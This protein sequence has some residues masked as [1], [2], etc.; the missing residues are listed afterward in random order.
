MSNEHGLGRQIAVDNR[1]QLHPMQSLLPKRITVTSKSWWDLGAWLDQGQTGTCV[2]H[3]WAHWVEDSPVNPA[4]TIDPFAV[5][6]EA[7]QLDEWV[8][9]DDADV[10][11]GTSVRGGVKALQA[12]GLVEQ[13]LWAWDVAT[14]R[15]SVLLKG[16]VI[17]GTN[18]YEEMFDPGMVESA[19]GSKRLTLEA[20]GPLVGG[21]AYVLNGVNVNRQLFRVKNSWGREWGNEGRAF[22]SFDTMERLLAEEGEACMAVQR[23]VAA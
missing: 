17:V 8:D 6:A 4:D 2:G 7:C 13:Y 16:P 20:E 23:K 21:H 15:D 11:W 12:R 5:Y 18:W 9:N 19:D 14:V 1:D 22:I 3:A 10:N